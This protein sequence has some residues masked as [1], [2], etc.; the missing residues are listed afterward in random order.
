MGN[1][2]VLLILDGWGIAPEGPGNAVKLA[3]TPNMDK[4]FSEYPMTSLACSGRDVGLPTGF[5]GNSEVGHMNIGAGRIVYQDMTRIDL[6]IEDKSF[7]KNPVLLDIMNKVKESGGKLHLL[8]LV[9]DGGVHSHQNHI[10]QLLKMAKEQEVPKTFVHAFMDGR[11]TAPTSGAGYIEK[12]MRTMKDMEYGQ[13]ATVSGR[14]WAMDRDKHFERNE[15]AYKA[16][17]L[18][19]GRI[20]TDALEAVKESYAQDE[21]DEFIK[22]VVISKDGNTPLATIDGGDAVFFF[23]FRADRARQMTRLLFDTDFNE[24]DREKLPKIHL[25]TM[26]RYDSSFPVPAAFGPQS[27]DNVLGQVLSEQGLKQL[28][29][30]ET[31]KYAHVTYFMNCG[32]EE[33]FEGEDRVM[34]PSPREV[35]TYD[36]K[37]EMSA[38]EVTDTLLKKLDEYDV[39]ICNLANLDMVGHTGIIPAVIQA[40]ETVDKCLGEIVDAVL[41]MGGRMLLTADHGNSEEMLDHDGNPQTAHSKNPVPF[42]LI[43][44]DAGNYE[45]KQGRLG[46]IAPTL[47]GLMGIA[48]PAEMTGQNLAQNKG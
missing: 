42:L 14:Y 37:P 24:F 9:S 7:F 30:A 35:A 13:I 41:G 20:A 18:G 40:C 23:N 46:D 43:A 33:P 25:A 26:T 36:L 47:L 48:Q 34:I 12:L 6:A 22:P 5:M 1:K 2:T 19:R 38:R 29:L 44:E 17:V 3:D 27:Y 15:P 32:R 8:G 31:E 21:T 11:D 4:V 16:M 39:V 45:L 28:R 10:D